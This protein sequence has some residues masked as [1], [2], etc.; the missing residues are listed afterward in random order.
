MKTIKQATIV[1][2]LIALIFSGCQKKSADPVENGNIGGNYE[3]VLKGQAVG[4]PD[5]YF[6][7][8]M[9]QSGTSVT[10][11]ISLHNS[12][13]TGVILGSASGG[14][15]SFTVDIGLDASPFSFSGS[16]DPLSKPSLISGTVAYLG[17]TVQGTLQATLGINAD[18]I[19]NSLATNQYIFTKV[20]SATNPTG[21]PVIFIH[22]MGA[23]LKCWIGTSSLGPTY[24]LVN[25]LSPAF[26]AK[27]DIWLFQYNWKDSIIINGRALKDSVE[28]YGLIN[29]ILVGHSMG[30]LVSRGYVASGGSI[31][32]LVTLGTPHLGTQLVELI[33]IPLVCMMNFPG[34]R[35][36]MPAPEG[37]YIKYILDS[38]LDIANRSKYYAIAGQIKGEFATINGVPGWKW[39]IYPAD[40][41][42]SIDKLGYFLFKGLYPFPDN[43]GLVPVPSA[44]FSEPGVSNPL[45]VQQWIDHFN[46]V[47]PAHAPQ[48][49]DYINT[50]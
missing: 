23:N 8:T 45:Q 9:I 44:L 12:A 36:M 4:S 5:I 29:P 34:P 24:D 27:H 40:W 41:Y 42:S 31:S 13:T 6:I 2:A 3:L 14:L 16:F 39:A 49:L 28:L 30:G 18:S 15:L 43:D 46:L 17:Q 19:C 21:V 7:L 11:T 10:G 20:N 35:N 33:D 37:K 26:K 48:I 1:I 50:L 22:G 38:P 32:K 47:C 25:E